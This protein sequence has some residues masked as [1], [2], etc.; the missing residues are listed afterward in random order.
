[1]HFIK[2]GDPAYSV[3]SIWHPSDGT[4]RTVTIVSVTRWADCNN[5]YHYDVQYRDHTGNCWTKD[6]WNFQVR[7]H[8]KEAQ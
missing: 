6:I 3:G 8:F 2:A 5:P 4:G 1:M 7:Y